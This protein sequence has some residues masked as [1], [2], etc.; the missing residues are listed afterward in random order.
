MWTMTKFEPFAQP[1]EAKA[2]DRAR[3]AAIDLRGAL[4]RA[5]R[6]AIPKEINDFEAYLNELENELAGG[7]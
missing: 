4:R 2:I 7:G 5:G 6:R 1:P 3:N